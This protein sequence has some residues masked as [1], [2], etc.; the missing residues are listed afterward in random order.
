MLVLE[1]MRFVSVVS[2]CE[3]VGNT[4]RRRAIS[5]RD[6]RSERPGF[7]RPAPHCQH[8]WRAWSTLVK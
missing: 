8:P 5:D 2:T 3:A 1:Q 4:H 7:E 6:M